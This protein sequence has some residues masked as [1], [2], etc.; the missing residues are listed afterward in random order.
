[1]R[2]PYLYLPL[3]LASSLLLVT[4][5]SPEPANTTVQP[6]AGSMQLSSNSRDSLDWAGS[7]QGILPCASCEGI[8]TTLTLSADGQFQL[9]SIYLG[10]EPDNEFNETGRFSWDT[11]GGKIRLESE[12]QENR[13]F[14]VEE[15]AVRQLDQQG[16][17]ITGDLA[18][19]YRLAK[20]AAEVAAVTAGEAVQPDLLDRDWQLTELQGQAVAADSGAFIHFAADGKVWGRSGCNRFSGRWQGSAYRIQLGQLAGTMMACA[21]DKMALEQAFLAQLA[22]ADNYTLANGELS[23]NKARM[24]PLARFSVTA[25]TE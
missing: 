6:G 18:E 12:S 16:E 22:L 1:M 4:A 11:S 19:H 25:A 3:L 5:C 13:W 9:Q 7:Y 15:N 8:K 17:L 24:A 2:K 10:E 21:D 14:R 20:V 23:L